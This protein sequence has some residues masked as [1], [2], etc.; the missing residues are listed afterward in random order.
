M[1]KI[2]RELGTT[3]PRIIVLVPDGEGGINRLFHHL[4]QQKN[5]G[6]G[7]CLTIFDSTDKRTLKVLRFPW[8]LTRFFAIIMGGTFQLCHINLSISGS[9]LRKVIYA[10]LCRT[11]GL[12]YVIH[13]HGS[14]YR[15]FYANLSNPR[16]AIVRNFFQKAQRVIVLGNVWRDFVVSEIG[17]DPARAVILANAVPGPVTLS[18]AP[19]SDEPHLLFLG[20]LGSRKGTP[21]LLEALKNPEVQSLCWKATIAGDGPIEEFREAVAGAELTTRVDVPGWVGPNEAK[22]LLNKSEIL[23]LP[24]HAENLPLSMLEGMAY[25]LCPV[26]TPVGAVRDAIRDG[27]NGLLVPVNDPKALACALTRLIKNKDLRARLSANARRD[28]EA[29]YDIRT[30]RQKLEAT[31]L[32]VC[33]G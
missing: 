29:N 33:E 22:A 11:A 8:R 3:L 4:Q 15:E 17:V 28:F 20:R 31:Y 14:S 13:L 26:V 10:A 1:A 27:E 18:P 23:L 25:G 12:P 6:A 30:Y 19:P 2:V 9:T 32:D 16:Q 24:S 7:T 5:E 21:E